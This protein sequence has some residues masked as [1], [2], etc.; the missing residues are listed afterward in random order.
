MEYRKLDRF[1]YERDT[2][3]IAKTLLGK[4]LVHDSSE[5]KTVGKIVETEAYLGKDDPAAH[6]YEDTRTDR[7]EVMFG[8]PG[9]AYVYL[10]YGM[11]HCF[12]VVTGEEGEP[13]AVFIRALEPIKGVKLMQKRRDIDDISGSKRYDLTNG[14]GKL[15]MAMDIDKSLI[16]EDLRED[17]L[18][19]SESKEDQD[20]QIEEAK[21]INI[22]YADEAAEWK[23][24]YYISENP[25]VS[26]K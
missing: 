22:D 9:H 10:I 24:R 19:I 18:F 5:G 2:E 17:E 3:E 8:P 12:N 13:E 21:R 25:Y 4:D 6:T 26:E 15:C 1:F 14:P 7:T 20:F 11:Y 16:G 23:L